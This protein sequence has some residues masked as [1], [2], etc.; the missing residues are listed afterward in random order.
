MTTSRK[1]SINI[2]PALRINEEDIEHL[3]VLSKSEKVTVH[4]SVWREYQII[5]TKTIKIDE[6]NY[7][8]VSGEFELISNCI[9]PKVYQFLGACYF[10]KNNT[11]YIMFAFEFMENGNLESFLTKN[12]LEYF[13]KLKISIDIMIALQYLIF[14]RPFSIIHR[15]FKPTNI[16]VNSYGEVKIADFGIS[17][18]MFNTYENVELNTKQKVIQRLLK[19]VHHTKDDIENN[20]QNTT[21]TTNIGSIMWAAPE[22]LTNDKKTY[23]H[24]SDIYSFGLILYYIF[25]NCKAPYDLYE[26]DNKA[27]IVFAK[28][29]DVRPYMNALDINT[30]I[31][32]LITQCTQF[33]P[34][35]R[36][37]AKYILQ[38]LY[39][40]Y[41]CRNYMSEK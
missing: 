10:V 25:S 22:T 34:S 28:K 32:N 20:I 9:H 14:R 29:N 17:K 37:Q 21:M 24:F 6:S 8:Y 11:P 35:K 16:L 18:K 36:P 39:K 2:S 5:C 31:N 4:K 23:N 12:Y 27:K 13:D 30:D 33:V 26:Y 7:K 41:N 40:L 19:W 1:Y 3:E 38:S 15:D